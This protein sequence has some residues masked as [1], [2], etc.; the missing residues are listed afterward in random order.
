MDLC[1]HS[2]TAGSTDN[3]AVGSDPGSSRRGRHGVEHEYLARSQDKTARSWP[4]PARITGRKGDGDSV[5]VEFTFD[6]ED[7]E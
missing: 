7:E 6:P 2:Q 5:T 1:P 3:A 4:L